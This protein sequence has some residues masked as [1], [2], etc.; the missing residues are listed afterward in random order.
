MITPAPVLRRMVDTVTGAVSVDALGPTLMHEHILITNPGAELDPKFALDR[1][2][3][4]KEA[5]LRLRELLQLGIRTFVDPCPIELGRD[6]RLLREISERSGMQIVCAT[7]FYQEERGLPFYWRKSTSDE[8]AEFLIHEII[9]GIGGTGVRPGVIKC[10]SSAPQIGGLER[11]FLAAAS[12]AH[13]ETGVPILTHTE[14]GLGGDSQQD[15]FFEH[16]VAPH[17]ALIGHCC[18]NTDSGYHHRI[19]SR[20]SYIGFDRIGSISDALDEARADNAIK[21][22]HSGYRDQLILS[23]DRVCCIR[24]VKPPPQIVRWIE[25]MRAKGEWPPPF[26]HLFTS[27]LPR[28]RARGVSDAD[29]ASILEANP[30][31]F[32][33]GEKPTKANN[34]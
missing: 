6:V 18:Q 20:G 22:I 4:V 17:A 15:V 16:G 12:L 10:A 13:Q 28:L 33:S 2:A 29:I 19:V 3:L 5:V 27:F 30:R 32:F 7:G 25:E 11:K 14:D 23:Q 34:D 24:G 1:E 26:T 9:N 21:L 31:R 8:I